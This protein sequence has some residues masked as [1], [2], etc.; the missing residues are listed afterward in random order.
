MKPSEEQ[1]HI[2]RSRVSPTINFQMIRLA[3]II[4]DHCLISSDRIPKPDLID[5][6]HL[7]Q[8]KALNPF[9]VCSLPIALSLMT[10]SILLNDLSTT[11]SSMNTRH[12]MERR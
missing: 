9:S 2:A 4:S 5:R 6:N 10:H 12:Y 1:Q 3:W 8:E 7:Y 11:R